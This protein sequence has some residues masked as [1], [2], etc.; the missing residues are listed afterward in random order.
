MSRR[1]A[2]NL[3][4]AGRRWPDAEVLFDDDFSAGYEG[5]RQHQSNPSTATETTI[6]APPSRT[7]L[8][9]YDGGGWGLLLGLSD[10]FS[11]TTTWIPDG[12]CGTLKNLSRDINHG[13]ITFQVWYA[14]FG[15]DLNT[16]PGQFYFG[17]DSQSWDDDHRGFPRLQC[18]R[19]TGSPATRT[20]SWRI[21][22]DSGSA[23][24]LAA[25]G[26]GSTTPPAKSLRYPG[27]NENKMNR[28]YAALTYDLDAVVSGDGLPGSYF[29]AEV[30]DECVDLRGLGAGRGKQSPQTTSSFAG[31]LNFVMSVSNRTSVASVTG[32]LSGLII[33][34]ARA[35]WTPPGVD[36]VAANG[37]EIA[38]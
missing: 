7:R 32:A 11:G 26:T 36:W 28:S 14:M 3:D 10:R 22:D 13:K 23:I 35:F 27:D 5:W 21:T 25:D 20:N 24:Y 19:F 30:G 2:S 12:N 17:F 4:Q 6:Y 33:T 8:R 16:N 37:T 15:Q 18:N 31:G 38:A 34:R 29:A 1:L 9:D